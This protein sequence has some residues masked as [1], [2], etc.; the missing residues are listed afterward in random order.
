MITVTTREAEYDVEMYLCRQNAKSEIELMF[1]SKGIETFDPTAV[2]EVD[3][4]GELT[5][6]KPG[7]EIIVRSVFR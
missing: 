4:D 2:V 1:N 5:K 6:L 3:A 7:D